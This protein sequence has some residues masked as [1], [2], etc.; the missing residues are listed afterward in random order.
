VIY[1]PCRFHY[2]QPNA[3]VV[4]RSYKVNLY[5]SS[6]N[7]TQPYSPFIIDGMPGVIIF[8]ALVCDYPV[9]RAVQ[10]QI[11]CTNCSPQLK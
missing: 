10:F 4:T 11:E 7:Q 5:T 3:A 6:C 8:F 9:S 1:V 2:T